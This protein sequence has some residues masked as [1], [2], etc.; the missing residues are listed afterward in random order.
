[1]VLP[2]KYTTQTGKE[3]LKIISWS[4]KTTRLDGQHQQAP[5]SPTHS[6]VSL[7]NTGRP[8][9]RSMSYGAKDEPVHRPHYHLNGL[10]HQPSLRSLVPSNE[11]HHLPGMNKENVGRTRIL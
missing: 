5:I 10:V 6:T 11:I 8:T 4:G 1:M 3:A 7:L 2:A 9:T